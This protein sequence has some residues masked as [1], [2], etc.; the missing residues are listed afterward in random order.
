M[1]VLEQGMSGIKSIEPL[2]L[3]LLAAWWWHISLI[4]G[5][6]A[7]AYYSRTAMPSDHWDDGKPKNNLRY[8]KQREDQDDDTRNS[9]ETFETKSLNANYDNGMFREAGLSHFI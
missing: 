3:L 1:I 5:N 6:L 4:Q 9:L 2:D 7:I 8:E